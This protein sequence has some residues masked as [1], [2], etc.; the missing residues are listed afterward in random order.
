M[1]LNLD[2]NRGIVGKNIIYT[3]DN[4]W[5]YE[6][7]L[8]NESTMEY[9]VHHGIVAGRWVKNQKMN[10]AQIAKDI[11]RVSWTE[12]T[13][14]DVALTFNLQDKLV[15]GTIYFPRWVVNEPHKIACY[16]N[17]CIPLMEKYRDEGPTYPTEVIDQRAT[18]IYMRNCGANNETVI[19]CA[20]SELPAN[21]PENLPDENL[22]NTAELA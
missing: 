1:N 7:Y 19:A 16:Q 15:H 9:R 20:P 21:Y 22:L 12:P 14:T 17:D 3:Y 10:L 4:G 2:D 18:M 11:Y 8:K 5:R 13:G 6:F